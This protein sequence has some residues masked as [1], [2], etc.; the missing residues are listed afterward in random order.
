LEDVAVQGHRHDVYLLQ[1]RLPIEVKGLKVKKSAKKF[2]D[3]VWSI[4]EH[5]P[6]CMQ[7]TLSK[8]LFVRYNVKDLHEV[9]KGT[10]IFLPTKYFAF[11][12][13]L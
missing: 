7:G 13:R 5:V 3:T 9:G 12:N 1:L 10:R 6:T 8:Y 4:E 2:E 11:K